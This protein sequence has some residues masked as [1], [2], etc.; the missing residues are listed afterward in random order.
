MACTPFV[1]RRPMIGGVVSPSNRRYTCKH[2]SLGAFYFEGNYSLLLNIYLKKE[3]STW[4]LNI[5]LYTF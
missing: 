4:R 5:E 2:P 1:R 3:V